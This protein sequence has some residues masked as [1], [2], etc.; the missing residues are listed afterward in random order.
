LIWIKERRPV[1]TSGT[2]GR[3]VALVEKTVAMLTDERA[4]AD[5]T[6][7]ARQKDEV[8]I[9]NLEV[10]LRAKDAQADGLRDRLVGAQAELSLAQAAADRAHAEA[11]AVQERADAAE[12]QTGRCVAGEAEPHRA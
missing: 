7:A 9:A 11:Q 4:R 6:E 2:A 5:R 1:A 10:D 12:R 8:L 3:A